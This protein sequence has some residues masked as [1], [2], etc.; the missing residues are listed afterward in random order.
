MG[1][2]VRNV[3]LSHHCVIACCFGRIISYAF[4]N[5]GFI[6]FFFIRSRERCSA[7]FCLYNLLDIG[8]SSCANGRL[9]IFCW[10]CERL[11]RINQMTPL[12]VFGIGH[13]KCYCK[14]YFAKLDTSLQTYNWFLWECSN[15]VALPKHTSNKSSLAKCIRILC[16]DITNQLLLISGTRKKNNI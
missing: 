1:N 3:L 14:K 7:A 2:R 9:N 5:L 4:P 15:G 8:G 16:C 13:E 12:L 10:C 11:L 6:L